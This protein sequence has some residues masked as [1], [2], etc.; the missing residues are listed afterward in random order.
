VFADPAD[1]EHVVVHRQPDQDDHH[2]QRDPVDHETRAGEVEGACS[3]AVLEHDR[4]DAERH[5]HRRQVQRCR[6][7]RDGNAAEGE[8]HHQ[9]RQQEHDPD[10]DRQP[11]VLPVHV[12]QGLRRVPADGVLHVQVAQRR[13]HEVVAESGDRIVDLGV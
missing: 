4:E 5:S 3:P 9:Q 8:P 10:H 13:R 7:Q 11:V 2:E 1:H 12:V 6:D